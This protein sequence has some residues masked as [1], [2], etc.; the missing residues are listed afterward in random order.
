MSTT[1]IHHTTRRDLAQTHPIRLLPKHGESIENS[2]FYPRFHDSFGNEGFRVEHSVMVD[3]GVVQVVA[4]PANGH[5]EW[6]WF[7]EDGRV[8]YTRSGWGSIGYA[9][10]DALNHAY[11]H[12]NR[13]R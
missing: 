4:D 7:R 5:T 13:K 10:Q 3:D 2:E 8:E 12:W 9:L 6:L 1:A 11:A